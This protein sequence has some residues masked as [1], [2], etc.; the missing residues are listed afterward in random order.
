MNQSR[1]L[2]LITGGAGFIGS[3]LA[4][5]LLAA[6]YR[7]RV[8]DHL[9]KQVH[10]EGT[11]PK[12]LDP[13][14]EFVAGDILDIEALKRAL[15]GVD[16]VYHFAAKV[17][18]GQS[19]YRIREYTEVNAL[20]TA[21]LLEALLENPVKKLIVAS[22]MSVYGE[23]S[24]VDGT[25]QSA[26]PKQRR[27]NHFTQHNSWDFRGEGSETLKP[28]PTAESKPCLPASMYAQGKYDQE[29]M[30]LIFGE[31]YDIPTVAMRFFN[32]YGPRQALS[33]PYTG[34]LAI[35]AS[36]L[37]N[38]RAPLIFE[39]GEQ[40][41]DFVHV[42]DVACACRLALET[43]AARNC[44]VNVGSGEQRS[45]RQIAEAII[46]AMGRKGEIEPE[47]TGR[48]RAGD[49][50]HCYADTTLARHLLE[51]R[52]RVNFHDGLVELVG[53]LEGQIAIDRVEDAQRELT[54]RGLAK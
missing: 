52:P 22:S 47:I 3:H 53:W 26:F 15:E 10:P 11:L 27:E 1:E 19:M 17:G 46:A 31:A 28:E 39:D 8:L 5:E 24:Y 49:V 16:F 30:C 29:R 45:I 34:V 48:F 21:V 50:R 18:V 25:G 38:G 14:V 6:G 32:V 4:D 40:R 12:Y 37:M 13:A 20:G 2:V 54:T 51:Y 9:D 33:N 44:V 42:K 35:F 43:E 23:G 36:R 7:V 41:R